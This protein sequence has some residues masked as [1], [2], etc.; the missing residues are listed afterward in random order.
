MSPLVPHWDA[1]STNVYYKLHWQPQWGFRIKA[2][3][4]SL[5]E[6]TYLQNGIKSSGLANLRRQPGDDVGDTNNAIHTVDPIYYPSDET[7]KYLNRNYNL[8]SNTFTE[9]VFTFPLYV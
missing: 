4:Y 3:D 8:A 5:K 7:V 1:D 2:A 6:P 9:G